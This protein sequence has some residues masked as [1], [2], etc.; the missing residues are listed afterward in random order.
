[1]ICCFSKYQYLFNFLIYN[2]I[3]I[4]MKFGEI[5]IYAHF[6]WIKIIDYV[7]LYVKNY[8]YIKIVFDRL[9]KSRSTL[10]A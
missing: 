2:N 1:M 4:Y 3:L 5:E 8:T 6:V 7:T 9:V 10:D